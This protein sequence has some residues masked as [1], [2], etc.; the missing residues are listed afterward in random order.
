MLQLLSASSGFRQPLKVGRSPQA[1]LWQ[2]RFH[3]DVL[4]VG[5][6]EFLSALC[7]VPS[8][9]RVSGFVLTN[10]ALNAVL[11]LFFIFHDRDKWGSKFK[12]TEYRFFP[13]LCRAV[14]LY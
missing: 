2:S 12:L 9:I 7:S 3:W 14:V 6:F 4:V 10:P 8:V 13:L 11:C 5:Q 1:W